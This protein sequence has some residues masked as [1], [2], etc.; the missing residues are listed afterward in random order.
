MKCDKC[1]GDRY[2]GNS[3]GPYYYGYHVNTSTRVLSKPKKTLFGTEKE[4]VGYLSKTKYQIAGRTDMFI[5]SR[6]A[7]RQKKE[8][9]LLASICAC[10][11]VLFAFAALMYTETTIREQV[12][13][14]ILI[15]G[16]LLL[17]LAIANRKNETSGS[18]LAW[19]VFSKEYRKKGY[20][21]F[22]SQR[23]YDEL[24]PESFYDSFYKES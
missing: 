5:C 10:P 22:F 2:K 14:S 13:F 4:Y 1:G 9:I 3:W 24:R 18:E 20:T 19:E 21:A 11:I 12:F 16:P 23:E 8:T 15:L 6:C 7:S 17:I